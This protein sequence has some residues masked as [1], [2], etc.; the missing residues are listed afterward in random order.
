MTYDG[1]GHNLF[2]GHVHHHH[3]QQQLHLTAPHA[4]R[5]C[6]KGSDPKKINT[7]IKHT[8]GNKSKL[9]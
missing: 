6:D 8:T 9:V 5:S 2:L 7:V 4:D 3:P 1:L